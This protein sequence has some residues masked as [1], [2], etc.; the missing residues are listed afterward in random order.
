LYHR[1]GTPFGPQQNG[2]FRQSSISNYGAVNSNYQYN[3]R[4]MAHEM[5]HKLNFKH[6]FEEFNDKYQP[7]NPDEMH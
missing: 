5:G 2:W 6:P 3:K 7:N 1:L 4:T